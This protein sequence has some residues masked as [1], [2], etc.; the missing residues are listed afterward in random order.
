[1]SD[2]IETEMD[3]KIKLFDEWIKTQQ[4]LPQKIGEL[5]YFKYL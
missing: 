4:H 2:K 5:R 1:M 3:L